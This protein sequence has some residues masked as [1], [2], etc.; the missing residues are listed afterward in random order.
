MANR[1]RNLL[2]KYGRRDGELVPIMMMGIDVDD[3]DH[4]DGF[5]ARVGAAFRS[6]RMISPPETSAMFVSLTGALSAREFKRR[7]AQQWRRDPVLGRIM[8]HM[9]EAS[10]L[11]GERDGTV[12]DHISLIDRG[13]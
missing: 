2:T 13:N 7:W 9:A 10:V 11:Y 3:L 4:I 5:M 6:Q 8:A 12:I 1:I